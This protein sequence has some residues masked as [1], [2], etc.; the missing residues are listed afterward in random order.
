MVGYAVMANTKE[1]LSGCAML[2]LFALMLGL[3]VS[4]SCGQKPEPALGTNASAEPAQMHE[5]DTAS[6]LTL[7]YRCTVQ[8][9]DGKTV[10]GFGDAGAVQI[11]SGTKCEVSTYGRNVPVLLLDGPH[12]GET[13]R[14]WGL[15]V[16]REGE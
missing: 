4:R 15:R 16:R 10:T 14:V 13:L 9:I 1:G 12:A 2:V 8:G 6:P 5:R 11:A 7:S 3:L